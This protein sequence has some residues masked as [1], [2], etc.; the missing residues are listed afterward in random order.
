MAIDAVIERIRPRTPHD[1]L[2]LTLAPRVDREGKD[3][4]PGRSVLNIVG[5]RTFNPEVGMEV[6]G[7]ADW[8]EVVGGPEYDR[9]GSF[10]RERLLCDR[11]DTP[12]RWCEATNDTTGATREFYRCGQCDCERLIREAPE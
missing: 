4:C 12:M 7:G 9:K 5:E 3:T 2:R 1:G 10:L 8:V 6:W 11:C